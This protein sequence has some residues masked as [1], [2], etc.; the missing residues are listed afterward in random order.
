MSPKIYKDYKI[1][2]CI[3]LNYLVSALGINIYQANL[4]EKIDT[5]L[6]TR[7]ASVTKSEIMHEIKSNHHMTNKI[8]EKLKEDGLITVKKGE[9]R[10]EIEITKKGVLHIRK[11]NQFYLEL[12]KE[13]IL[14]HYRYRGL[15]SWARKLRMV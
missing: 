11:Y 3:V 12:Y 10:F 13:Q 4:E 8:I 2:S 15:P 5:I 9:K 6:L 14:D 7:R 1:Y